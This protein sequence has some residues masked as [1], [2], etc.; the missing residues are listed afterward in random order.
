MQ[1][2]HGEYAEALETG[3]RAL[4]GRRP[5]EPAAALAPAASF[6]CL[7]AYFS[8]HWAEIVPFVAVT[9]EAWEEVRQEPGHGVMVH[10]GFDMPLLVALAQEDRAAAQH[11]GAKERLLR[12]SDRGIFASYFEAC[13]R[14]DPALLTSALRAMGRQDGADAGYSL[15]LMYYSERGLP[16]PREL[17]DLPMLY[18]WAHHV[19][20]LHRCLAIAEALAAGDDTQL[21]AAIDDAEAHG[22]IPHAARMRIVLARRIGDRTPLIRARPVLERLGDRQFLRRLQEVQS[23]L[24]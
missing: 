23:A 10:G 4:G 15:L 11:S 7:A 6:A 20:P 3:R 8:G 22:L 18:P 16:A 14:D 17:L 21:A 9:N 1:V 5:G 12:S 19:D 13:L 24:T 2:E